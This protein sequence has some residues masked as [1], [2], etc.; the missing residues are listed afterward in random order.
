MGEMDESSPK[1]TEGKSSFAKQ[2]LLLCKLLA[3][4]TLVL[5]VD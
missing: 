4:E 5:N 1:G 2:S 3:A